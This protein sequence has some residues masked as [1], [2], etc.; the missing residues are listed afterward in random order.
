M[1]KNFIFD[2]SRRDQSNGKSGKLKEINGVNGTPRSIAPG[3]PDLED[4]FNQLGIRHLRFHDNLG[5]GDLDNYFK[6]DDDNSQFAPNIPSNMKQQTLQLIADIGNRRTIF[7][8]AATGMRIHNVDVAFQNA[9]YAMTDAHFK[10]VLNNNPS[11]N[12]GNLQREITFR[13]GRTNRGGA[14]LPQDFDIYATLVSTLI[15]R[16][17]LNFQK[18]GL[19]GKVAY[20]EV[21]NEPDLTF[22]WNNNDPQRYYEFYEKIARMI[23]AVDPTAKVGG[24]GVANGYNPG[25]GIY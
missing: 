20:W 8:N 19:P 18:T 2:K 4:Q 15:D 9:N 13:I 7:P 24:A 3:F 22:F 16:Y 14:E 25:G 5:F 12:P 1:T 21:W 17:S 6:P 11:V 10:E 23:K